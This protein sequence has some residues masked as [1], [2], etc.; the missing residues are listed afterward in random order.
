MAQAL[1][2]LLPVA[3]LMHS[4]HRIP[5]TGKSACATRTVRSR[6]FVL[7]IYHEVLVIIVRSFYLTIAAHHV[8]LVTPLGPPRR[9]LAK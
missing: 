7:I 9:R 5:D 4:V 1:L 3:L 6:D 2:P 8:S